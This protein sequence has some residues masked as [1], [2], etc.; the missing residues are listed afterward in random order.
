MCG[1]HV[2]TNKMCFLILV[3]VSQVSCEPDVRHILLTTSPDTSVLDF[4]SAADQC[5]KAKEKIHDDEEDH[6]EETTVHITVDASATHRTLATLSGEVKDGSDGDE[7][8]TNLDYNVNSDGSCVCKLCGEVVASR[9]HWYRHK[10][11]VH[12]VSLFRCD[13]CEIFFKSKK[14]YEGH[15]SNRHAPKVIGSDGKPKSRKEIEGLNKVL[16]EIQ[17]KKEL[18]MVQRIM[19]QVKAE[20]EASGGDIDRKGYTK[21]Y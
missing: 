1:K 17:S 2:N 7:D 18:E 15:L 13:Q 5:E 9:T 16:K 19:A 8:A 10:Y 3:G 20:C 21:H 11:K 12:N 6:S 14:G 4:L